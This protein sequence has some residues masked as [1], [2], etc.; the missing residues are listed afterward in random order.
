MAYISEINMNVKHF[1]WPPLGLRE[2]IFAVKVNHQIQSGERSDTTVRFQ[3]LCNI[4]VALG[5]HLAG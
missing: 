5:E 3:H 1:L 2:E 4:V